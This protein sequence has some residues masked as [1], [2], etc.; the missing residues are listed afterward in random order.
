VAL[1]LAVAHHRR[2]ARLVLLDP[3]LPGHPS[4]EELEAFD[5]AEEAALEEGRVDDAVELNVRMWAPRATPA[6]QDLVR[7]MQARAFRLQLEV[8]TEP[9]GLD[10]PVSERLAEV[11][12]P[13]VVAHGDGDVADFIAIAQRLAREL[14]DATLHAIAGAGHLPALEQ[15]GAVARLIGYG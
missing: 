4:S 3:P 7:E 8:E 12:M 2:V 5:A 10:P 13:T 15:P 14:P 11:V 6:Q 1:E 9:V